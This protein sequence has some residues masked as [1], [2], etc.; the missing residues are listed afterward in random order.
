MFGR[1][2]A[3]TSFSNAVSLLAL[4]V[5]LGGSAYAAGKITGK[6]IKDHTITAAD[7]KVGSLVAKDFK[8]GQLPR[9]PRGTTGAIGATGTAG[10]TGPAGAKG[11][12]GADG[13]VATA[14][15]ASFIGTVTANANWQF[16]GPTV[17]VTVN[18]SQH[19]TASATGGLGVTAG[20]VSV[21]VSLC[22]ATVAAPTP[23]PF[24]ATSNFVRTIV[25]TTRSDFSAANSFVPAAATYTVGY[26]VRTATNLDNNDWST[27]WVEVTNS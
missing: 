26:C 22:T 4:F 14:R 10:A 13:T 9:G 25:T 8:A 11:D 24:N 5:A 7:I 17:S 18:G 2:R 27:G 15:W 3:R 19:L 21:D 12:T 20:S 1:I 23:T 16:A 6:D